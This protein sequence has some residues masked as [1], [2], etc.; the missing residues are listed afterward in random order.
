MRKD[1]RTLPLDAPVAR[2]ALGDAPGATADVGWRFPAPAGTYVGTG[3]VERVLADGRPLV[4]LQDA[5][6][7]RVALAWAIPF[8]YVPAAA[9]VLRVIG[10]DGRYY[11]T[12]IVHG[13]GRS[14][15]LFR[16]RAAVRA[17][18]RVRLV[19]DRAV[20]LLGPRIELRARVLEVWAGALQERLGH[21]YRGVRGRLEEHAARCLRKVDGTETVIGRVVTVLG[22]ESV[23][24]DADKIMVD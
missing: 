4:R 14:E 23:F 6:G 10:R 19:G 9:D 22:V 17:A 20:R 18:G 3:M 24:Y 11:A 21:A 5:W 8:R 13:Q 1:S 12:G 15:L 2:P 16:E 7:T